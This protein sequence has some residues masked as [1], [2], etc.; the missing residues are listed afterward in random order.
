MIDLR[1]LRVLQA[2]AASGSVAGAAGIL[3]LTPPAVSQQLKALER[4]AGPCSTGLVGASRSPRPAACSL[5]MV[6]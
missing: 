5:G 3:R 6:K 1:R 4:E 2:V